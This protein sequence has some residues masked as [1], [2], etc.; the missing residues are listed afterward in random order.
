VNQSFISAGVGDVKP[1]NILI[2]TR[3]YKL[4]QILSTSVMNIGDS[5]VPIDLVTGSGTSGNLDVTPIGLQPEL[6]GTRAE[7][8]AFSCDEVRLN[9]SAQYRL[10]QS[11]IVNAGRFEPG[12]SSLEAVPTDCI[13]Q[14]RPFVMIERRLH[15]NFF[16]INGMI[17]PRRIE[18]S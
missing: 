11:F 14:V 7:L 10:S 3:D 18:K 5:P 6:L 15:D 13:R 17:L 12:V 9:N 2:S 8:F 1:E 4:S 16:V